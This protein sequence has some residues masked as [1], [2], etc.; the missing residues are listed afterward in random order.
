MF[1]YGA[2]FFLKYKMVTNTLLE[3]EKK[4]LEQ[5][6]CFSCKKPI[7]EEV[8]YYWYDGWKQSINKPEGWEPVHLKG[9]ASCADIVEAD[10]NTPCYFVGLTKEEY[11]TILDKNI[12]P[13]KLLRALPGIYLQTN[14][15]ESLEKSIKNL[16]KDR[17]LRDLLGE[18]GLLVRT[19][20]NNFEGPDNFEPYYVDSKRGKVLTEFA[21]AM[22]ALKEA[23]KDPGTDRDLDIVLEVGDVLLQKR[24]V[25]LYYKDHESYEDV[26]NKFDTA[27]NYLN[28]CIEERK[29]N[30]VAAEE[31]CR[32]KYGVRAWLG[33]NLYDVKKKEFETELCLDV[34]E[35]KFAKKIIINEWV[36][37]RGTNKMMYRY[38]RSSRH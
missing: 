11:K 14:A 24:I 6:I 20:G 9:F 16:F 28:G 3:S 10:F 1:K 2:R 25:E 5:V 22:D 33:L 36:T 27:L 19:V 26:I 30:P 21:E 34:Y 18:D 29:I 7:E 37:E 8:I 12:F 35:D 17:R 23:D 13:D 31:M 38:E 4:D 15:T 32:L